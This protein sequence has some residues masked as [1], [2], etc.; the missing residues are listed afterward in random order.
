MLINGV[1]SGISL[2]TQMQPARDLQNVW[3][4][5]DHA[6]HVVG[7]I[8]IACHVYNLVYCK[9]LTIVVCDM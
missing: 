4:M 2:I 1:E 9:M 8:T 5:L 7:W 3:I 6:K